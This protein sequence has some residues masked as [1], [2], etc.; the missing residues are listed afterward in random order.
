MATFNKVILIGNLTRDPELQYT[1][2]GMAMAKFSLAVNYTTGK[3]DNK[4]SEADFF[5]IETWDKLAELASE[6]LSKGSPVLIEGRL[7]QDRW[8]D[9]H[10]NQRSR[11][12]VVAQGLQF[13]PKSDGGKGKAEDQGNKCNDGAPF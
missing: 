10:G 4:K 2:S 8:E 1:K 6:Y 7:K 3:G 9:E 12:K 13:L 11:V 5:D